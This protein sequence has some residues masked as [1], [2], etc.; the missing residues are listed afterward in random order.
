[1][2]IATNLPD[3]LMLRETSVVEPHELIIILGAFFSI[4]RLEKFNI[5]ENHILPLKNIFL[6]CF[7]LNPQI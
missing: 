7:I 5:R 2:N 3:V 6:I 1:M 4:T